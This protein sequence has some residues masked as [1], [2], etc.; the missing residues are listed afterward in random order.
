MVQHFFNLIQT[1]AHDNMYNKNSGTAG[2]Q[3]THQWKFCQLG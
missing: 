1:S 3:I 2:D